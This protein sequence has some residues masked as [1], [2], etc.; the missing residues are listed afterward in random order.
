MTRAT[1]ARLAASLALVLTLAGCSISALVQTSEIADLVTGPTGVAVYVE[2]A[3]PRML[4]PAEADQAVAEAAALRQVIAAPE[5]SREELRGPLV[6]FLDTYR[7]LVTD[8]PELD[9]AWR[10][11]RLRSVNILRRVA[12]LSDG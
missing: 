10:T 7:A 2:E 5:V 12:G 4:D 3:A 9:D 11:R 6:P 8:D 1:P